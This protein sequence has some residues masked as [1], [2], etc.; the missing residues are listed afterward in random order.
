MPLIT[1]R[2]TVDDVAA[3]QQGRSTP[4]ADRLREAFKRVDVEPSPL[5]DAY[6][7]SPT[8]AANKKSKEAYLAEVRDAIESATGVRPLDPV[9]WRNIRHARVA[10]AWIMTMQEAGRNFPSP[11][12][13]SRLYTL[14]A[15]DDAMATGQAPALHP[16]F[17]QRG[18]PDMSAIEAE[19]SAH[20]TSDRAVTS[21]ATTGA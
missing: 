10:S 18:E 8:D 20:A 14:L 1:K 19:K 9:A 11:D 4:A 16:A 21:V 5:E 13:M 17:T 12:D 6:G 3:L 15:V 7:P 2:P